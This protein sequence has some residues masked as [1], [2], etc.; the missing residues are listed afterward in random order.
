MKNLIEGKLLNKKMLFERI[1][2]GIIGWCQVF[3][4]ILKMHA[5]ATHAMLAPSVRRRRS[6]AG[7]SVTACLAGLAGTVRVT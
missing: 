2:E 6:T 1:D 3:G 5:R 4:V 7:T